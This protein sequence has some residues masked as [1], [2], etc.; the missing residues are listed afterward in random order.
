M[1]RY[2][3]CLMLALVSFGVGAL[4]AALQGGGQT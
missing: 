1:K 2:L 3:L 4:V